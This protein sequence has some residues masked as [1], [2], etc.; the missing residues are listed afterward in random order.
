MTDAPEEKPRQAKRFWEA[1][2]K[3]NGLF[4]DGAELREAC[5]Q[6]FEWV[7]ENPLYEEKV[8]N[9]SYGTERAEVA[10]MRVMTVRGLCL[11]L[12]VSHACWYDKWMKDDRYKEVCG[13]AEDVILQYKVEGAA[14]GLLTPS[15]IGK[16][17]G[18]V[19]QVQNKVVGAGEKGEIPV[20]HEH[21]L[22]LTNLTEDQLAAIA[23][24]RIAPDRT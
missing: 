18:L 22:D 14:A 19:D 17:I 23:S 11:F 16:E 5:L 6:Y 15:F 4:S 21:S 2:N 10:K 24:I 12:G 7:D 3:F 13:W 9:N 8:F 1:R 20:K